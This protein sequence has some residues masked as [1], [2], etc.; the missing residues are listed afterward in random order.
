MPVATRLAKLPAFVWLAKRWD[1]VAVTLAALAVRLVWN[2][3]IHRPLD[4]AFS[5]MGGYLERART[6]IDFPDQPRGYFTL[7]PWGTHWLLSL[8]MR[9]FGKDNGAAIA[10]VYAVLGALA[11]AYGF[12]LAQRLT[13]RRWL[14]RA[15]GAVLAVY[16]PWISLGG[17]T[18]SEPPFTLFLCATAYH[19]LAYADRGRAR[20]AWLF[21]GALA[22]GAVFRPQI[23][24]A[25]PLYALHVLLRRRAWRRLRL[26]TL[27]PAVAAPL[28]LVTAVSAVRV[29]FHTGRYGFIAG[30]G[31]LNY[32]F[33]RCHATSITTRAPDRTS[34]YS[35]PSLGGLA[36]YGA[37]HPGSF[38][39]LDPAKERNITIPDHHIW[40]A[41]P[42]QALAS[43]C[44]RRTGPW[45]QA[46]YAAAHVALLWFFNTIWPD[47]GQA[48]FR[49]PMELSLAAHDLFVLPPALIAMGLAFRRRH[50]RT[51]LLALHVWALV[52][53]AIMYFGDTR[54]RAPYDGILVT[55]AAATYAAALGHVRR[56]RSA[57]RAR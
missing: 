37:S 38:F 51:M 34:G 3:A 12:A 9:A 41:E 2:L 26:R 5:D 55:L 19:G 45:R 22:A 15:V 8:V 24:A 54:L 43:E 16:Y 25:L 7:F 35:P 57:S 21:G 28:L 30:N 42:F 18:L 48:A 56:R 10:V 46:R 29:R 40:D 47:A 11:V 52:G 13:R 17:Y 44:V 53:V 50:A 39:Q 23:L 14:A 27:V 36:S 4:F 20:D 6:S 49:R 31:P 1:L 32:A 33:G